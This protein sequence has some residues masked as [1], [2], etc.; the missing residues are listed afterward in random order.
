MKMYGTLMYYFRYINILTAITEGVL[1]VENLRKTSILYIAAFTLLLTLPTLSTP[2]LTA[3]SQSNLQFTPLIILAPDDA[4]NPTAGP[5]ACTTPPPV[6]L[7]TFFHCYNPANITKAYGVD[8]LY[9]A[10][11]N[12]TGETIVIVDAYGSPTAQNDLNFFSTTFGLPAAHLTIVYPDGTP[13]WNTNAMKGVKVTW[14][15][16]TSLDLQWAHAIAP[17][18]NLVLVATNPAETEGV[19]GFPNMFKGIQYAINT[20]PGSVISQ[21]FAATEQS[22]HSAGDAQVKKFDKVYQQAVAN[23]VTVIG[24]SGDT[25]TENVIGGQGASKPHPLP[26]PTVN[27]PSSDPLVTSAGGTWLQY[28]W[29][30]TPTSPTDLSYSTTPGSRTEAVWNEPFLPAATGGGLSTLFS[31][32]TFQSSLPSSLLQGQRGLPDLSWN[33][34]VDGG[35]LVYTSFPGTRVGWHTVGGTSAASPQLAALVALANQK[36]DMLGK[37]HHVGYLNPIIYTLPASAFIDIVP[38]RFGTVTIDNNELYGSG[39]S[40]YSTTAGYDLTTG[41]GSPNATNFVPDLANAL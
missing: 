10:G 29:T 13:T 28:N 18:A 4:Q 21:S 14:A 35:V 2:L 16:E 23:Y 8:S 30:W 37:S 9:A 7:S 34:A 12:G 5:F 31:T 33:A 36:A 39:V 24:S 1:R 11:I 20:Y 22:F 15:V 19:Q 3:S 17:Y 40:G 27:W 6:H 32:P 41:F 25:G 26:Y 38:Q